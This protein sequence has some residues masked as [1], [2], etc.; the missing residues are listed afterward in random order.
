MHQRPDVDQFFRLKAFLIAVCRSLAR[1][2]A[3]AMCKL[4]ALEMSVFST[5]LWRAQASPWSLAMCQELDRPIN[6]LLRRITKNLPSFPTHLLYAKA[7][8]LN[9]PCLSDRI[10]SV[11]LALAQRGLTN[12]PIIAAGPEG[13]IQRSARFYGLACIPGNR[14]SFGSTTKHHWAASLLQR[15]DQCG[16]LLT[17]GG[18]D[19]LEP[20]R[21]KLTPTPP[22]GILSGRS[23]S[24][25]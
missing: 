21:S 3:T 2:S 17:T 7:P 1:K 19:P 16:L 20:T 4:A 11:K 15:L 25:H 24:R 8:G 18:K 5:T 10:Q 22:N 9:L 12:P 13:L 14:M 6:Q 23:K